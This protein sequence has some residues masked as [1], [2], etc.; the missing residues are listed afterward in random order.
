[1]LSDGLLVTMFKAACKLKA[2]L[3]CTWRD[4]RVTPAHLVTFEHTWAR[5]MLLLA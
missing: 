2:M 4:P 1:M 3:P 5:S